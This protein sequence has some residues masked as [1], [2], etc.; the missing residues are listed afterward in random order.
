MQRLS[1]LTPFPLSFSSLL[2]CIFIIIFREQWNNEQKDLGHS[3]KWAAYIMTCHN[4]KKWHIYCLLCPSLKFPALVQNSS[5]RWENPWRCHNEGFNQNKAVLT[6]CFETL[7]EEWTEGGSER[8]FMFYDFAWGYSMQ[9]ACADSFW[10]SSVGISGVC[11]L[12]H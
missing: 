12:S 9:Y 6:L 11:N 2:V 10:G 3:M 7:Q 5:P 4:R 8:K 1:P